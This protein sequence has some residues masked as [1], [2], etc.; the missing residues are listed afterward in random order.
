MPKG[1]ALNRS[2]ACFEDPNIPISTGLI[3]PSGDPPI[4]VTTVGMRK[5]LLGI[6]LHKAEGTI[7]IQ[8]QLQRDCTS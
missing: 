7:N 4:H 6:K 5:T 8:E 1:D 3:S 2:Y